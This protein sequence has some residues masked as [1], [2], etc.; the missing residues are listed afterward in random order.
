MRE[1]IFVGARKTNAITLSGSSE[2]NSFFVTN[3]NFCMQ[4]Q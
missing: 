1:V 3:D 4:N 2:M